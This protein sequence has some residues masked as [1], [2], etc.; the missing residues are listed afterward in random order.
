MPDTTSAF[1]S[2]LAFTGTKLQ[3][4]DAA[5][6][7]NWTTIVNLSDASLPL[8]TQTVEVTNSG[9]TN[10][11][12]AATLLDMGPETFK[13]FWRPEDPTLNNEPNGLRY[14]QQKRTLATWRVLYANGSYDIFPAYVTNFSITSKT[15]DV[16]HADLELANDGAPTSLA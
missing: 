12:R 8:K 16:W 4:A 1:G 6:P 3:L 11:R 2:S 14:L 13:I 9:D 7:P 10:V 15:G 5:S